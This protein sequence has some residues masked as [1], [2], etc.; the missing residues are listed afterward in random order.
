M[1]FKFN[2]KEYRKLSNVQ[3]QIAIKFIKDKFQGYLSKNLNLLRVSAPIFLEQSTGLND[4]L[5]GVERK[6]SFTPL[7]DNNKTLEVIQSLAK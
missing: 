5:N 1:E 3:T 2:K 4:D 6:V 7:F